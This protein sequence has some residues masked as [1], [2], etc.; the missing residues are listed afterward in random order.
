MQ[1]QLSTQTQPRTWLR[2]VDT[3]Q[4]VIYIY[5]SQS[6]PCILVTCVS[7][8]SSPLVLSKS[9]NELTIFLSPT[10]DLASK[11]QGLSPY[12][13]R[14]CLLRDAAHYLC[15]GWLEGAPGHFPFSRHSSWSL[16]TGRYSSHATRVQ[17]IRLARN[18]TYLIWIDA[19][20]A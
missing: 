12:A 2:V 11:L 18:R 5:G 3:P 15:G 17:T 13:L 14:R 9:R 1:S 7:S 4:V 6:D 8:L 10:S 20:L 16:A 19:R